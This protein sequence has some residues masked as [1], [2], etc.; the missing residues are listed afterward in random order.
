MMAVDTARLSHGVEIRP[1]GPG[2]YERLRVAEFMHLRSSWR[3]RGRTLAPAHYEGLIWDGVAAQ[4]ICV[5]LGADLDELVGWFQ[6]YNYEP[7]NRIGWVAAARFGGSG[8]SFGVGGALFIDHVVQAFDVV[9]L[10]FEVPEYN[11]KVLKAWS[12]M[13]AH[14]ATI[15][16]RI[17]AKGQRWGVEVW[18]LHRDDFLEDE[19]VTAILNRET[20]AQ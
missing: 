2:D 16:D 13:I 4:V 19:S 17:Y 20:H 10:F 5:E 15:P 18:S 3:S 11:G 8:T 6:L 7:E 1:I 12:P 14:V 9:R